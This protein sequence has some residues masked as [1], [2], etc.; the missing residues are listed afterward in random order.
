MVEQNIPSITLDVVNQTL[1]AGARRTQLTPKAFAVLNHLHQHPGQL[2]TKDELLESVWPRVYVGD[3]VLKVAVREIRKALNDDPREPRYIETVHRRG[4][5]LIGPL[6]GSERPTPMSPLLPKT[7]ATLAGR[8][9]QLEQLSSYWQD[10]L[11]GRSQLVFINGPAGVGKSSLAEVWLEHAAGTSECLYA[12]G[13]CLQHQAAAEAYL[14]LL[15]AL[16]RLARGAANDRLKSMLARYAPGWLWQLPWLIDDTERAT[17]Q[18]QLI[19]STPQRMLRELAEFL[20]AFSAEQA[21]II[22]LEDL[23]WCD[24]AT[25][26]M[27]SYFARRTDSARTDSART[28]SARCLIIATV[29]TSE[30]TERSHPLLRKQRELSSLPGCHT[31]DLGMLPLAAVQDYLQQRCPGL[32]DSLARTLYQRS[33]G[34]PLYVAA[35]VDALIADEHLVQKQGIWQ[36]TSAIDAIEIALPKQLQQI[37]EQQ[38]DR[39]DPSERRL[40][41]AASVVR[42]W[43]AAE[44]VAAM[45]DW[46]VTT[47]ENICEDLVWRGPWL[48]DADSREW[49]D[50]TLSA[51]YGFRNTLFRDYL[52]RQLPAA[53]RRRLHQSLAQRLES[54][55]QGQ[56]QTIA[57]DLAYHY[58]HGGNKSKAI[59]FYQL[60]AEVDCTRFAPREA[61]QHIERALNLAVPPVR[62]ELLLQYCELLLASGQ[63]QDAIGSYRSLVQT[64]A[65]TGQTE[66]HIKAL[67]GLASALFWFDRKQCLAVAEQAQVSSHTIH[68][69]VLKAHVEGW[70]A[71]WRTLIQGYRAEYD[72]AYHQAVRQSEKAGQTAWRCQHLALLAYLQTLHADYHDSARTAATGLELALQLGDGQHYLACQFFRAWALFYA[73][74]WG[75]MLNVM[76]DGYTIARKNGHL[77]WIAH[78]QLQQAWLQLH[79]FDHKSA[80][81]LC[82]PIVDHAR[83]SGLFGSEFFL[84]SIILARSYLGQEQRQEAGECLNAIQQR[85]Q[86]APESID[87]ILRL[88]LQQVLADYHLLC[89][90]WPQAQA[91]AQTLYELAAGPGEQTYCGLALTQLANVTLAQGDGAAAL[92]LL[93]QAEPLAPQAPVAAGRIYAG[94]AH[95]LD[96]NHQNRAAEEY[97]QEAV[98]A[99][100][101]LAASLSDHERQREQLLTAA[102]RI[103]EAVSKT[104]SC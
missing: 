35:T 39:L 52:Y 30:L 2:V 28:D 72:T 103:L 32:D 26:D 94:L 54:A 82:Q 37:I 29:D 60:A 83:N 10:A 65:E 102:G 77:P 51:L 92:Q 11:Q 6:A 87:W 34:H 79:I 71:H 46:D 50:G 15:D 93:K 99:L 36:L 33:G 57:A 66:L 49:P 7:G 43:F 86:Q 95:C 90:A 12:K 40:L 98:T 18:Q 9:Q 63:M 44:A 55:Y 19:G 58:E 88:P 22:L 104:A 68:D 3:A 70:C 20:E 13:N 5:R 38:L 96:R 78:F 41:D 100:D 97:R 69:E 42:H 61:A 24:L 80:R 84:G 17:L 76:E 53:R 16:G 67:L 45:L 23:H 101:Q 62:G 75:E 1:V 31:L 59:R 64:S 14:P 85:L 73:G 27:L 21:L 8:E 81:E 25:L 74:R 48:Q 91:A 56:H 47:I 4:Y 89:Q